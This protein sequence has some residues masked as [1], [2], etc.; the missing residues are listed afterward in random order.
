MAAEARVP[1]KEEVCMQRKAPPWF[2][3]I[4]ARHQEKLSKDQTVDEQQVPG[5]PCSCPLCEARDIYDGL[6]M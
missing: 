6:H 4:S 1:F 3:L 2:P 5:C